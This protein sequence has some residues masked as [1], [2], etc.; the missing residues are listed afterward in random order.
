MQ[1]RAK[2]MT[3]LWSNSRVND[4]TKMDFEREL[5]YAYGE[6]MVVAAKRDEFF[7]DGLHWQESWSKTWVS[8]STGHSALQRSPCQVVIIYIR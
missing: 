2:A 4:C 5:G 1:N 6:T 7:G 3:T 8:Q